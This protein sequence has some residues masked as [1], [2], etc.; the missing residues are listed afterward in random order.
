LERSPEGRREMTVA[1]KPEIERQRRQIVGVRHFEQRAREAK[2]HIAPPTVALAWRNSARRRCSVGEAGC[3]RR[4][5][6]EGSARPHSLISSKGAWAGKRNGDLVVGIS[7][8]S[9][10]QTRHGRAGC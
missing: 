3:E 10:P 8:T 2:A 4:R 5:K 9:A 1:R 6:R 7:Q